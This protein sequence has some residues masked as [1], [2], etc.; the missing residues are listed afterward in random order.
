MGFISC[1]P[2]FPGGECWPQDEAGYRGCFP[3]PETGSTRHGRGPSTDDVLAAVA[4]ALKQ[5]V[6]S[7]GRAVPGRRTARGRRRFG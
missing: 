2:H 3:Q 6:V 4:E 5:A 7:P 1:F